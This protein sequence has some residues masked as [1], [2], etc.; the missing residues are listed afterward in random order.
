MSAL[1][2][3]VV[4]APNPT[5]NA[6]YAARGPIALGL[7]SAAVDDGLMVW[8]CVLIIGTERFV[9]TPKDRAI[10]Q[11]FS[12]LYVQPLP[13]WSAMRRASLA[14]AYLAVGFIARWGGDG[15]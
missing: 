14:G 6:A 8:W 7:D 1:I 12:G 15:L 2:T 10:L 13:W 9:S 11:R 4:T 3:T 5:N